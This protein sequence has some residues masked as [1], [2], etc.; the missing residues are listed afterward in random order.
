VPPGI[1]GVEPKLALVYS[2]RA[3][4]GPFGVGWNLTGLSA[5]TRC[6]RT[7]AQDG[8][9]MR[10][11]VNFDA[12]DRFCL[13]GSRLML[14]AGT[15]AYGAAGSEYRTEIPTF[16]K[17]IANGSAGLSGPASFTAYLRSGETIQYGVTTNSR[18]NGQGAFTPLT[19]AM[20]QL[21][22]RKGNY[23]TVTYKTFG[24]KYEY[25]VSQISYTGSGAAGPNQSVVFN[26]GTTARADQ[27]SGYGPGG[28]AT[29]MTQWV[30]SIQVFANGSLVRQ[31]KPTYSS[32][33]TSSRLIMTALQECAPSVFGSMTADACLPV[34]SFTWSNGNLG[35]TNFALGGYQVSQ[36]TGVENLVAD[37]SGD[38]LGDLVTTVSNGAGNTV[39]TYLSDGKQLIPPQSLQSLGSSSG[40]EVL[41]DVDGDGKAD[42][43]Y[44]TPNSNTNQD[45]AQVALST[46]SGFGSLGTQTAVGATGAYQYLLGDIDGDGRADLVRGPVTQA[47]GSGITTALSTGTGFAAP[48]STTFS[49]AAGTGYSYSMADLNGDGCED[50]LQIASSTSGNPVFSTT[51][52]YSVTTWKSNCS[53]LVSNGGPTSVASVTISSGAAPTSLP[54]QWTVGDFNGDGRDDLVFV[55]PDVPTFPGPA[56][57]NA[58]LLLSNNSGLNAPIGPISLVTPPA[59]FDGRALTGVKVFGIDV[60]GDGLTDLVVMYA[61]NSGAANAQVFLWNGTT[62]TQGPLWT[63]IGAW[64]PVNIADFPVDLNGDSRIDLVRLPSVHALATPNV[65]SQV[66]PPFDTV[67]K[68]S[69]GL[70]WNATV[71]YSML[72]E[73]GVSYPVAPLARPTAIGPL[74]TKGTRQSFPRLD[75]D[76]PMRVVNSTQIDSG[77][78]PMNS[79]FYAYQGAIMD[80]QGRGFVGFSQV[81]RYDTAANVMTSMCYEMTFPFFGMTA[82]QLQYV[83]T[84]SGG[85][86]T[87][88]RS[89]TND[90]TTVLADNGSSF[91]YVSRSVDQPYEP[92]TGAR[93]HALPSTT[94]RNT[95]DGWGQLSPATVITSDGFSRTTT[96]TYLPIDST[97]NWYIG[98]LSQSVVENKSPSALPTSAGFAA[99]TVSTADVVVNVPT[100]STSATTGT[101]TAS[102]VGNVGTVSYNWRVPYDGAIV[103]SANSATA[104]ATFS[105]TLPNWSQT[106]TT[107]A[108]VEAQDSTTGA[109]VSAAVPVT[110]TTPAR[111]AVSISP[112]PVVK[113]QPSA[114]AATATAT[115]SATGGW[116]PFSYTWVRTAGSRISV[117]GGQTATFSV[118][119]GW[120]ENLT[121]TF[122]VTAK[123]SQN[124]TA[125]A[126]VNV[127]FTTPSLLAVSVT[128][129]S[130]SQSYTGGGHT[131]TSTFTGSASGGVPP[132]TYSWSIA[133]SDLM[134]ITSGG[135]STTVTITD[136]AA[137]C[138]TDTGTATLT[139]TDSKGNTGSASASITNQTLAKPPQ[140]CGNA[141]VPPPGP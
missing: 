137:P 30:S 97:T 91:P 29:Q 94:T 116:P 44:I 57:W 41:G 25:E 16:T 115:A 6:A 26:Y 67:V 124:N 112:N 75:F 28:I 82:Q 43:V 4:N 93:G 39:S 111:P 51:Y 117:S 134:K 42:F 21:Q 73:R 45:Q 60:N 20:N 56:T 35:V 92:S 89:V 5:I 84:A 65:L 126:S 120:N 3:G 63:G 2:S 132:Y 24:G 66:G 128:P 34:L 12:N 103:I 87:M 90:V 40:Q 106:L 125:V 1:A 88:L 69:N 27:V 23:W 100:P 36:A 52:N 17:I 83:P 110:F 32:S 33:T 54:V 131:F 135:T 61:N 46:G 13:N 31:Y 47:G 10:G 140:T 38:G 59:D 50:L 70:G 49:P 9:G 123:D 127:T 37:V 71:G 121:E 86:A 130:M 133:S 8:I 136:T 139:V 105:A 22:D 14:L 102:A 108:I 95:F 101:G 85:I 141:P 64:D 76:G 19:W 80:L 74:Y 72:S 15:G 18:I 78:G 129:T 113:A 68:F 53:T 48:V 104:T 99:M 79:T 77:A 98:R 138:S 122:Q 11:S 55:V 58:Y 119:L 107:I 114:G 81:N 96:N 7:V 118:T 62:F 109:V